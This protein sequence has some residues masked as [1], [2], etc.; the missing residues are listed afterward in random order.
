MKLV[1]IYK[2]YENNPNNIW[3]LDKV[4]DLEDPAVTDPYKGDHI[5]LEDEAWEYYFDLEDQ[6]I[7]AEIAELRI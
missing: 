2:R 4:F 5:D 7:L 6:G 3:V 1:I